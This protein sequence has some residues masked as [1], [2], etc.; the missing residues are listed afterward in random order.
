M[1]NPKPTIL[2]TED[3]PALAEVV[4]ESLETK[5]FA[6]THVTNAQDAYAAYQ[7]QKPNL[8]LLD[9]MLPGENGFAIAQK[10]RQ[11]DTDT[12]ILFLT[13]RSLPED[14]VAGFEHGGNDYLKKPF[15]LAELVVRIKALLS[16]NRLVLQ[17]T[18]PANEMSIGSFTFLYNTRNLLFAGKNRQLTFK[19]AELLKLLFINRNQIIDRKTLLVTVWGNDDF[20]TGRSLDVFITKLRSYLSADASVKILN[21][22]G[23]GYKLVC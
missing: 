3:E 16:H 15:S 1:S 9:V 7:Q 18:A 22:R 4:K 14:V 12:P 17:T 19:E 23:I 10:I 2:F 11:T 8:L 13:A 5:G 6:V 20:F 21:I